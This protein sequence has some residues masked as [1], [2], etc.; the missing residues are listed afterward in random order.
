M[1]ALIIQQLQKIAKREKVRS[2]LGNL[3]FMVAGIIVLVASIIT[4][5]FWSYPLI[6]YYQNYINFMTQRIGR[7]EYLAFFDKSL[8]EQYELATYISER[9]NSDDPI[10]IWGDLPSLYALTRRL[11]PGRFTATYHVKDFKAHDETFAAILKTPPKYILIDKRVD[12]FNQ[13]TGLLA[14]EYA[15]VYRSEIF[16]LYRRS[17]L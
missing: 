7:D 11:P 16:T 9:T 3:I 17:N 14:E 5:K 8:P 6:P 13:L 1:L 15:V 2:Y 10:F 12:Q 4:L